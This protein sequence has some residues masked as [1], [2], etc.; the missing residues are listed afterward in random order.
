M[1]SSATE[2]P[3]D[4]LQAAI[5]YLMGEISSQTNWME[6]SMLRALATKP[7][8]PLLPSQPPLKLGQRLL[9]TSTSTPILS[10]LH[11]KHAMNFSLGSASQT[12]EHNLNDLA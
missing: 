5:S 7:L 8:A 6:A 12:A 1:I 3:Q 2:L 4:K 10:G 11:G 9:P